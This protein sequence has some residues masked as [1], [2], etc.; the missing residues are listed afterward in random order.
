MRL[1]IGSKFPGRRWPGAA[2]AAIA[3]FLPA[4]LAWGS[5]HADAMLLIAS[6]ACAVIYGEGHGYRARAKVIAAAGAVLVVGAFLGSATGHWVYA[7]IDATGAR[8]PLLGTAVFASCFAT[9][10]VYV[11]NAL[12]LPPPGAFFFVMVAGAVTLT[13]KSGVPPLTVAGLVSLGSLSALLVGMS[14]ALIDRMA[15]ERDAV[16][17]AEKAV[18]EFAEAPDDPNR[19]HRASS[20]LHAAWSALH[21]ADAVRGGVILDGPRRELAER[22]M[23]MRATMIRLVGGDGGGA[24]ADVVG[25]GAGSADGGAGIAEAAAADHARPHTMM[26]PLA[27]P[28]WRYRVLRSAGL[29]SHAGVAATRVGVASLVVG[30]A[31][32]AMGLTRPDW[33]I[34]SAVMVLQRGPDRISGSVRSLHR[35]LGS[36][37]G[38]G[39]FAAVH[40]AQPGPVGVLL[41][42]MVSQFFAEVFVPRNYALT[43]V[44]T[45]PLALLLGDSLSDPLGSTVLSRLGEVAVGCGAA[46]AVLW[47][48]LPRGA[49]VVLRTTGRRVRRA[50]AELDAAR[51]AVEQAPG[52]ASADADEVLWRRRDLQFELHG[53]Q[54]AAED[55]AHDL[56]DWT[57]RI[58]PEHLRIQAEGYASLAGR[59]GF[60]ER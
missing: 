1:L 59:E 17:G 24:G 55:A 29:R 50:A 26:A 15:P 12:R 34:V 51:K 23:V 4:L 19:R 38:V 8:W 10:L 30:V 49:A 57:A 47:L 36:I 14:G 42:L 9:V 44:A 53:N 22:A 41:V 2:R 35:F 45:T 40:A 5:G 3:L 16:A 58:W 46:I 13:G 56:P 48:F 54:Y 27:R 21:D 28:S 7:E 60:H 39:L 32:V 31:S 18:A 6:G 11:T 52:R 33:A 20:A 43:C 37:V 25:G